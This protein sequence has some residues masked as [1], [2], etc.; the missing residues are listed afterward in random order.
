MPVKQ[1]VHDGSLGKVQEQPASKQ[2]LEVVQGLLPAHDRHRPH[3]RRFTDRQVN[4]L[5]R[6]VRSREWFSVSRELPNRAIHRHECVCRV[7]CLISLTPG[8]EQ[9]SMSRKRRPKKLRLP[10]PVGVA[11]IYA[12]SRGWS[13]ARAE[14]VSAG[15][16]PRWSRS[17][18]RSS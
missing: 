18:P 13:A 14:W 4:Q 10:A 9:T 2:N 6:A 8:G 17:S 15:V 5:H 3:L 7:D 16:T 1:L 11:R 12:R